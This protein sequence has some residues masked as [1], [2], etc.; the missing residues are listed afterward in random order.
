R[1]RKGRGMQHRT[2]LTSEILKGNRIALSRAITLV[3][4]QH[5]KDQQKAEE[6]MRNVLPH[7]GNSVRIG[8]TGVPG[9]GKSTFIEAFGNYLVGEGKKV[10]VLTVDPSSETG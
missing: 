7:S 3:E 8:I 10:A 6:L 1:I 2:N 9:A 5:P 4:S